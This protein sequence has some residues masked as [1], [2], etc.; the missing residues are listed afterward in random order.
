MRYRSIEDDVGV[1]T[2]IVGS[3]FLRPRQSLLGQ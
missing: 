1:M 3:D 2:L